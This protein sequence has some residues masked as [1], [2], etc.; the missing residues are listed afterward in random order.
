MSE[1]TVEEY[2]PAGRRPMSTTRHAL[3][4]AV[5][6]AAVAAR[7]GLAGPSTVVRTATA[8]TTP[9]NRSPMGPSV[10]GPYLR[11]G[12]DWL[13]RPP[14]NFGLV[15]VTRRADRQPHCAHCAH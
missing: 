6:V 10:A 11:R 4:A 12:S 7:V 15:D 9:R 2:C 14:T 3:G 1:A 13:G 5:A 8:N